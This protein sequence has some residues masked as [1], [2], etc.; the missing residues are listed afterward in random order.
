VVAVGDVIPGTAPN[1]VTIVS[2]PT[3][4]LRIS[5]RGDVLWTGTFYQ[6][7]IYNNYL[8][9]GLFWNGER[10]MASMDMPTGVNL[11]SQK[12]VNVYNSPYSLDMSDSGEWAAVAV[13]MQVPPYNFS[14][15][16]DNALIFQFTLPPQCIADFNGSG[17]VTVQDIFDFLAAYFSNNPAADVNDSGSVT[18]QD[19]FDFLAAY[20]AGCP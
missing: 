9:D 12:L 16:P 11:A 13:N 14:P 1:S 3:A 20:F 17:A 6:P 2:S 10:L 19:I 8:F 7:T 18:V 15:Q 4:A 5:D